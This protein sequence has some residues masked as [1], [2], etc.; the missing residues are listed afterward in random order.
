[1]KKYTDKVFSKV[2]DIVFSMGRLHKI[3]GFDN[4]I[5]SFS[6]V[7]KNKPDVKLLIAGLDEGSKSFLLQEIKRLGLLNSV[8]LIGQLDDVEKKEVLSNSSIFAL[9]SHSESFGIVVLEA[10]AS[11]LPVVISNKTIWNDLE[12]HKCGI[13]V[14]NKEDVFAKALLLSLETEYKTSDCVNYVESRY[15]IDVVS[16]DF[17]KSFCFF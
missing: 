10:L 12:K 6:L 16:N 1:M 7:L 14:S 9:C 8:F 17:V 4:L 15:D 3:K 5:R 11:G 2:S 13:F